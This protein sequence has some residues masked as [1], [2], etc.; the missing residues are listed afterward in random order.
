[1]SAR[2]LGNVDHCKT[3]LVLCRELPPIG[4][5]AGAVALN[6]ARE[7]VRSGYKVCYVTMHFGKMKTHEV[8][9]SSIEVWR[10]RCGRRHQDSS[11]VWEMLRFV[12]AALGL[13]YSIMK[14]RKVTFIHAHSIVPEGILALFAK[15]LNRKC[16][17]MV[18]SHGSDVPGYNTDRYQIIH[19]VVKPIWHF[20]IKRIDILT[21]PSHYQANLI[22]QNRLGQEV[23][24]IPNGVNPQLFRDVD[25]MRDN[26]FLIVSRLVRRKNYHEFI[27]ALSHIEQPVVIHI[28]GDGPSRRE[29]E[30]LSKRLSQHTF[31]FHGWLVHGSSAWQKL[32]RRCSFFVFPGLNENFPM[33]LLEAQLAK[34]IILAS[35]IPGNKEVL[36]GH[37][38]YFD[39]CFA[40]DMIRVIER[41]LAL[42]PEERMRLGRSARDRVLKD[43]TW[44][45]IGEEYL[46]ATEASCTI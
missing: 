33:N 2:S 12:L 10:V 31:H 36:G 14:K 29:L 3:V 20:L 5:G 28:V 11:Y 4:G 26:S 21:A 43:F 23:R 35:P 17:I 9:E 18:T 38:F 46:A 37:D 34:L 13:I 25:E 44:A 16:P 19:A 7:Y 41:A 39:G 24:V 40:S 45:K 1:M 42:P 6:V 22:R 32:Y 30:E 8:I 27:Q 15:S